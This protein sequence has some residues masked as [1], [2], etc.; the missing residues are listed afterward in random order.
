MGT[1]VYSYNL[2]SFLLKYQDFVVQALSRHHSFALHDFSGKIH[3]M[4]YCIERL[5]EFE[6]E[7]FGRETFFKYFTQLSSSFKKLS[8]TLEV[9]RAEHQS[10][11]AKSKTDH[12]KSF[13]SNTVLNLLFEAHSGDVGKVEVR[14]VDGNLEED[15]LLHY[16]CAISTALEQII[17]KQINF[18]TISVD[19]EFLLEIDCLNGIVIFGDFSGKLI[20]KNDNLIENLFGEKFEVQVKSLGKK[21]LSEFEFFDSSVEGS[22]FV[23]L[24]DSFLSYSFVRRP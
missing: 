16:L 2:E 3:A 15:E 24:E 23:N 22:E 19:G 18:E 13:F 20:V 7:S 21:V 6:L 17:R 4:D 1:K 10:F 9:Y 8:K 11:R 5:S 14:F 12:W